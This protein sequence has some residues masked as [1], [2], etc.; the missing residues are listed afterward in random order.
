MLS[1]TR[2]RAFAVTPGTLVANA[3]IEPSVAGSPGA[4]GRLCPTERDTRA[5]PAANSATTG[6]RARPVRM[7]PGSY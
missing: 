2:S 5:T 4:I 3:S 7:V 6:M 1:R